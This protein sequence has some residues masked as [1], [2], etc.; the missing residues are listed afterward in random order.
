MLDPKPNLIFN[1]PKSSP[2]KKIYLCET[3]QIQFPLK[4]K[5]RSC[6]LNIPLGSILANW[7]SMYTALGRGGEVGD[8]IID[9]FQIRKYK[10]W[11]SSFTLRTARSN[12]LNPESRITIVAVKDG[13]EELGKNDGPS[14]CPS[15]WSSKE[16][17]CHREQISSFKWNTKKGTKKNPVDIIAFHLSLFVWLYFSFTW[18]LAWAFNAYANSCPG[19]RIILT[20]LLHTEL[21]LYYVIVTPFQLGWS[22]LPGGCLFVFPIR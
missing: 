17:S 8:Q 14:R 21:L 11:K 13:G 18:K 6:S 10:K 5:R 19:R 16:C 1:L 22:L 7:F 20:Y 3:I 4:L 12:Y 9:S 15:E 2:F